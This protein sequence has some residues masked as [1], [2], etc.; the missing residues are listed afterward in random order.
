[1]TRSSVYARAFEAVVVIDIVTPLPLYL[2][3]EGRP[4]MLPTYLTYLPTMRTRTEGK[5]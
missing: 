2:P 1:M 5:I 3:A 4:L